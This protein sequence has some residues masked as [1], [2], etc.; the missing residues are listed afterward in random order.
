MKQILDT[1]HREYGYEKGFMEHV[2]QVGIAINQETR[3]ELLEPYLDQIDYVQFMGIKRIGVQGQPFSKDV[4]SSI[5]RFK[6]KHPRTPVQIDGGVSVDSAPALLALGVSRLVVG[7]AIWNTEHP[8]RAFT[9]LQSL[10][11][12]YGLYE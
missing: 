1:L 5:H 10:G 4:L 2:L 11:D 12:Q 7:S 3:L 6:E 8:D 9:Q